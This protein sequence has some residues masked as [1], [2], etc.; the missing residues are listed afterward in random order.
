MIF[1]MLWGAE[2]QIN[3]DKL[4]RLRAVKSDIARI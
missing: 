2:N 1:L 3:S 4:L